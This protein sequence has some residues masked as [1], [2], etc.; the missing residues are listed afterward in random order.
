MSVSGVSAGLFSASS[1]HTRASARL[2]SKTSV[3]L[4]D[5][6]TRARASSIGSDTTPASTTLDH[7]LWSI[8][9]AMVSSCPPASRIPIT[10]SSTS[11]STWVL[12]TARYTSTRGSAVIHPA[13]GHRRSA[14]SRRHRSCCIGSS[15]RSSAMTASNA[16]V[17]RFRTPIR[18]VRMSIQTTRIALTG[19]QRCQRFAFSHVDRQAG[20]TEQAEWM[21]T[22]QGTAYCVPDCR[23]G[24]T[25]GDALLRPPRVTSD[26]L[27]PACTSFVTHIA[28]ATH[29]Q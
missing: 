9:T 2:I 24:R 3:S 11:P 5:S 14:T 28:D 23:V 12:R 10:S 27:G 29:G 7:R 22:R 15:T 6:A 26:L 25:F 1:I 13:D 8:S 17:A 21:P 4:L 19:L 18:P 20:H 16:V